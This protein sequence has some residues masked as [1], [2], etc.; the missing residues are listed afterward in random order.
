[1]DYAIQNS[2][3]DR[4]RERR[5]ALFATTYK[6]LRLTQGYVRHSIEGLAVKKAACHWGFVAALL[7]AP[8]VSAC[9]SDAELPELAES[10]DST[11]EAV[12]NGTAVSA[13]VAQARGLVAIYHMDRTVTPNVWFPRVCS[14][15]IIR[16]VNGQSKVI[17][18]RHCVTTN[19]DT[20]GSL[21]PVG[22]FRLLP[23]TSVA[24]PNPNPPAAAVTP[25]GLTAAPVSDTVDERARDLAVFTV[26]ANWSAQVATKDP[27]YLGDPALLVNANVQAFG[28]GI[29]VS[30]WACQGNGSVTTGAGVA[31][32]ANP[33]KVTFS[34]LFGDAGYYTHNNQNSAGQAVICGDSGG[35]D[36]TTIFGFTGMAHF[37]GVHSTGG[38]T[39]AEQ[40]TP[41]VWLQMAVGGSYMSSFSNGSNAGNPIGANYMKMLPAGDLST[42]PLLYNLKTKRLKHANHSLCVAFGVR[43]DAQQTI[44]TILVSCGTTGN[45]EVWTITNDLRLKNTGADGLCLHANSS[46][47][48]LDLRPCVDD[49]NVWLQRFHFHPQP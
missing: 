37:T 31:R 48:L 32:T 45:N 30:N 22:D 11:A 15:K 25:V 8:V 35:P 46:S 13:A 2:T 38:T 36:F 9:G 40:S 16:S 4:R 27:L 19:G 3:G 34:K 6:T 7:F 49:G 5:V 47:N 12:V 29:N 26:N 33:F 18:A 28:Y 23:G 14:G 39:S 41:S 42:T 21:L 17:T 24:L 10:T 1:L 43:N 20:S 44:G